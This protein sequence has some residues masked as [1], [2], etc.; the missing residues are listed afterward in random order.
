VFIDQTST[1]QE[2]EEEEKKLYQHNNGVSWSF[3]KTYLTFLN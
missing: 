3:Q 1:K 2:E